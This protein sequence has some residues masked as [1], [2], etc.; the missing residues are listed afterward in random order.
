MTK[1][2]TGEALLRTISEE[3]LAKVPT[4]SREEI[5]KALRF[6]AEEARRAREAFTPP[7]SAGIRF[8]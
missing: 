6:G 5:E 1:K 2:I 3:E 7:A 8:R 4:L